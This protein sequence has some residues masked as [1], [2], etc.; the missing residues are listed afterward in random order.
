MRL[1]PR[2][3]TRRV[4][5]PRACGGATF[6]ACCR[7]SES[8]W[9]ASSSPAALRLTRPCSQANR[10]W[11]RKR[12][13]R[14]CGVLPESSHASNLSLVMYITAESAAGDGRHAELRGTHRHPGHQHR[15]RL[16][17]RWDWAP[18]GICTGEG[19]SYPAAR[20]LGLWCFLLHSHGCFGC[21]ICLLDLGRR[22]ASSGCSW[23]APSGQFPERRSGVQA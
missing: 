9:T 21:N 7:G 14:R 4:Y 16:Y 23:P 19:G 6:C 15:Q 12:Q 1:M 20:G 18:G 22:V 3:W 5:R 13:I 10:R 17:D 8:R 11:F 2:R